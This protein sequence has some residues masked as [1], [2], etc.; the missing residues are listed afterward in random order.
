VGLIPEALGATRATL[1]ALA[2]DIPG[3][4]RIDPLNDRD[5][6][7][8]RETLPTYRA[9]CDLY[10]R[11]KVRGLEQ[12]PAEGPVLLVGNH[13]GG[14][15]IADTFAFAFAFYTHFGPERRFHQLAHDLVFKVPGLVG[16]RRY[17]T[18]PASH[19]NAERALGRGAALLVYP[20]GDFETYRPSWRSGEIQFGGRS[21]FVRLALAQDVP[22]VPVVAIGGQET[23]LFLIRDGRLSRLLGLDRLTRVKVLPVQLA[24]PFGI[25]VLDLP[26]RIP[27]PAQ[28]TIQVLP[29]IDLRAQFGPQPHE[30]EVYEAVTGVMQEAL[31]ELSRE[32]DLPLVGSIGPRAEESEVAERVATRLAV[33]EAER[34]GES[35]GARS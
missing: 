17:G 24:P 6:E 9:L 25:T 8:I 23:A 31:D 15:L 29:K 11:P 13:S 21:G 2:G 26:G 35:A 5:P 16:L 18:M 10:F 33:S 14:T 1:A 4:R 22:I 20:G 3:L 27:L 30:R 7:F 34:T 32:R 12:I 28:I 19:G